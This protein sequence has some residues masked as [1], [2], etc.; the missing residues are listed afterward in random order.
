MF[1]L[2]TR[3][4]RPR[5]QALSDLPV[6]VQVVVDVSAHV[7]A[8]DQGTPRLRPHVRCVGHAVGDDETDA[9]TECS[10]FD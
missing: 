3:G 10:G 6:G 4:S 8:K 1:G 9:A 2:W 7:M 5:C